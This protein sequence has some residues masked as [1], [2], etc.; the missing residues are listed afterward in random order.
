LD[1]LTY[2]TRGRSDD[3]QVGRWNVETFDQ[4]LGADDDSGDAPAEGVNILGTKAVWQ[5]AVFEDSREP[6]TY[7]LKEQSL[8]LL[9]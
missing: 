8:D 7:G 3:P 2:R 4:G 6:H 1:S 5:L 9:D